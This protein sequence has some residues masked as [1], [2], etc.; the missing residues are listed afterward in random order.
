MQLEIVTTRGFNLSNSS[1]EMP[2][3]SKGSFMRVFVYRSLLLMALWVVMSGSA[4]AQTEKPGTE[5]FGLTMKQLV[6]AVEDV[7]NRIAKCMRQQGFEY[8]PADFKTI[9]RGMLADKSLPGMD[10]EEFIEQHGFGIS[11]FYTGAAPQMS[12]GYNPARVGL[13][14]KNV[15]IFK[16]LSPADQVAYNR[17]L[18]GKNADA[19]FAVALEQENFSRCGGCTLEAI[20]QVFKPDQ[21]GPTYLHPLDAMINSDPRM[22]AAV[23]KWSEAMRDEGFNYN[24]PDDVEPDLTSRLYGVTEGGTTPVAQLA[25]EQLAALK[26]LQEYERRVAVIAF[27][28]QEDIF[29]PVEEQIEKEMYARKV[30]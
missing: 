29:E 7:E 30:E 11:T 15:Q 1:I 5:E 3:V 19:T 8:I 24:H 16:N 23:R 6:K 10:E 26:K 21:L 2:G 13:G 12:D 17:A 9:R 28:L 4:Q 20:K 22:K 27:K 14:D 18:L 25:P